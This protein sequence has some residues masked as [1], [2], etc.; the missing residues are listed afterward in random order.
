MHGLALFNNATLL[1][2]ITYCWLT[3]IEQPAPIPP[4]MSRGRCTP[5]FI[6]VILKIMHFV[7]RQTGREKPRDIP[8]KIHPCNRDL[9][10]EART[11]ADVDSS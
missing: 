3:N 8:I 2:L 10:T 5:I 4:S 6:A 1:S 9:V 7:W 11:L